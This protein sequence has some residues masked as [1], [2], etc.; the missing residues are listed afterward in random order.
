MKELF[1]LLCNETI[2]GNAIDGWFLVQFEITDIR[3]AD[4]KSWAPVPNHRYLIVEMR[5]QMKVDG[6][7][8]DPQQTY[9]FSLVVKSD[10]KLESYFPFRMSEYHGLMQ[11]RR[12]PDGQ[13]NAWKVAGGSFF[14]S[15]ATANENATEYG[16]HPSNFTL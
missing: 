13:L 11:L 16:H 4:E 14:V 3:D 2:D 12:M 10:R 6:L 15:A 7:A 8:L 1:G 9:F 5:P